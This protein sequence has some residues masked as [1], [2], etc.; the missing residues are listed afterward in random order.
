MKKLL[1]PL[2]GALLLLPSTV[3]ATPIRSIHASAQELENCTTASPA[4]LTGTV[5]CGGATGYRIDGMNTVVF[6]IDY[7]RGA[8]D[9]WQCNFSQLDDADG[10]FHVVTS[11][12]ISLGISTLNPFGI[13]RDISVNDK[14][15]YV[16]SAGY[17]S[18]RLS[19]FGLGAPNASD[20]LVVK[21][22]RVFSP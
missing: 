15:S 13:K 2:L 12:N 19:C 5:N 10:T 21:A 9:G 18:V 11:Q 8:G 17:D 14:M 1:L 6:Y 22:R 4:V 16:L 20:T 3:N 7:T